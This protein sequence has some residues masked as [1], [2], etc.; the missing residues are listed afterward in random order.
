MKKNSTQ[1]QPITV[2]RFYDFWE[3]KRTYG[4]LENE[5]VLNFFKPYLESIPN[6]AMGEY[7]WQIFNNALPVPKILLIGGNVEKLTPFD[8]NALLNVHINDFFTIFHP[9]DLKPTLTFVSKSFEMLFS[10]NPYEVKNY[11]ISIYTRVK[12]SEGQYV[13]NCLQYPAL[14]FDENGDFLYGMSL[15]T[16]VHHLM[17]TNAKPMLTILDSTNKN[18]QIFTCFNTDNP[19]GVRQQY[20][21]VSKREREIIVLMA[22]GKASKQISDILGISK[23]T[24]DNHRQR[25]LKKF[26][27]ASS[28]ELVTKTIENN[29]LTI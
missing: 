21:K 2:E 1:L 14:Y 13:W 6:L 5:A 7:Y 4:S 29:G 28:V 11:N 23:R 18:S 26:N 17:K 27:A 16:N 19:A 3:T 12:N 8:G 22:Q 10:L 24:V 9:D 25:L 20:P 15:Y